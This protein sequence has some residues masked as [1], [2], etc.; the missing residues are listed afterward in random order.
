MMFY[1]KCF[2]VHECH[3]ING[4]N[5]HYIILWRRN[6]YLLSQRMV[7]SSTNDLGPIAIDAAI[8]RTIKRFDPVGAGEFC[9]ETIPS[10]TYKYV[11][12]GT[13]KVGVTGWEEK[14]WWIP[15]RKRV[16]FTSQM[17]ALIILT[18][19]D[20]RVVDGCSTI[21]SRFP[22]QEEVV[23]LPVPG[24]TILQRRLTTTT[25]FWKG[26]KNKP[27]TRSDHSSRCQ[28]NFDVVSL[29]MPHE[30]TAAF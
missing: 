21:T 19:W 13:Y 2:R 14:V 23:L 24:T 10:F 8:P 12:G 1:K 30:A 6:H 26:W 18:G 28:F 4:I 3:V 20:E 29:L 25:Y 22:V 15:V 11:P 16:R 5:H 17:V 7:P 9:D 27:I